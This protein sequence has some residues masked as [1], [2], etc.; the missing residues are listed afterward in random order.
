MRKFVIAI[1]ALAA[2][3]AGTAGPASAGGHR[4]HHG[5]R[6]RPTIAELAAQAP[7]LSILVEAAQKAGLVDALADPKGNLTVFAPTNDAFIALLGQLGL[8]S[9]DEVPV[10]TLR[11]ILLDHVVPQRLDAGRLD[12]YDRTDMEPVTLGGLTLDYDRTPNGVNDADILRM[13]I[14][15][16]NGV[17]HLV[18]KV[19]LDPD[20]R[21]T[22]AGLAVATPDLSILVQA[23][24]KAGLLDAIS[25][26]NA[27]L[28]VFA[29]TN[30]AFV[31][32][33]GQ[34][35]LSSLD[36]V[37]V[38][39]LRAILLDHVVPQELDAVDV[40]ERIPWAWR[41]RTLGG[42]TLDFEAGPLRVN[43]VGITAVDV[44]AS[45]GTVHVIDHV[46]LQPA[47]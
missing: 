41:T 24:Q 14:R 36:E 29:P 21:P 3:A 13:N 44:E 22:I 10:D 31:A 43:G 38:D 47:T 1:V 2:I 42:L 37:P 16:R 32:L 25:D 7:D 12:F 27:H 40:V 4:Y 11:A 20:P 15:A 39:T 6:H 19:L 17:V 18:D 34:L 5:D 23:V 45:N 8:S 33:L 9:L 28:T 46:L 35:G 30:A 26:P